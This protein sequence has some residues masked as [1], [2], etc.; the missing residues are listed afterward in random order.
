MGTVSAVC[1]V[2]FEDRPREG[3]PFPSN[4]TLRR[5]ALARHQERE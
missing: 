2:A 3:A 1:A 4:Q 5:R